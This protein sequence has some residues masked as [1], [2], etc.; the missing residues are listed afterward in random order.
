MGSFPET[1]KDN[2]KLSTSQRKSWS[3][4]TNSRLPFSVNR[5]IKEDSRLRHTA[6]VNLYSVTKFSPYFPLTLYCFHAKISSFMSVL[7]IG[8][9]RVCFYLHIFYSEKF[10]TL[11]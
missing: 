10:S 5:E 1:Y 11:V 9:V 8:I 3:P 6:D 2:E 7:T 4:G